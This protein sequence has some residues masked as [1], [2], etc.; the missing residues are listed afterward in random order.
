M[1]SPTMA[2]NFGDEIGALLLQ[3]RKIQRV[4]RRRVRRR[5]GVL[6]RRAAYEFWLDTVV[7]AVE[8]AEEAEGGSEFFFEG[9]RRFWFWS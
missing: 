4:G 1:M 8:A 2:S 3:M 6:K 7:V 9:E 5:P